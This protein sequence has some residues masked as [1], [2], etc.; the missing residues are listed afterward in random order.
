MIK[1]RF[2]FSILTP[3]TMSLTAMFTFV[4]TALAAGGGHAAADPAHLIPYLVNFIVFLGILTYLLRRRFI[5]MLLN[6]SRSYRRMVRRSA[7]TWQQ[8]RQA[9]AAARSKFETAGDEGV[10]IQRNI[11][12]ESER[13]AAALLTEARH[14]AER[15]I[16]QA[17]RTA[18][19]ERAAAERGVKSEVAALV[20]ERAAEQ[21]RR[22]HNLESDRRLRDSALGRIRQ[23]AQ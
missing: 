1:R 5:K 11:A 22:R 15:I 2:I 10:R 13:E 6:R 12:E 23:I 20:V 9:L 21:L 14:R 19:A 4:E 18:E 3:A 16:E 17:R 8:A 7:H